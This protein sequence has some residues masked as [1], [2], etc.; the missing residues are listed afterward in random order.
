MRMPHKLPEGT[1]H[2]YSDP[3]LTWKSYTWKYW[4]KYRLPFQIRYILGS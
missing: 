3:I 1:I 4:F 2:C